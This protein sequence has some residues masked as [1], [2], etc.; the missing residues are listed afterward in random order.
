[1]NLIKIG[2]LVDG[3]V[4][5]QWIPKL[6]ENKFECFALNYFNTIGNADFS[7]LSKK[8]KDAVGDSG[9]TVSCISVYAN[10]LRDDDKITEWEKC[11]DNARLFGAD[12]V[13]GFTGR[14][15]GK[16]VE[17]NIP[18]FKE[19][20]TE[21]AK[22]AEDKGVKIAFENCYMGGNWHN[23]SWNI[24]N[25]PLAW[26][27]MFDSVPYDNIGIE[28]E[29]SHHLSFLRDPLKSLKKYAK[30]VFHIHGKDANI[31]WDSIKEYGID[32]ARWY[33]RDRMP[34]YGD[35]NWKEVCSILYKNE[36]TGTIDI[37]GW[38][39][40]YLKNEFEFTGQVAALKYL[41]ECR[42]GE[43]ITNP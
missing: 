31:D 3:S 8:V 16:S 20:F 11:I 5:L 38:H 4:I 10:P 17:D 9:L 21:L 2:T 43:F 15:D 24:A 39:D 29:P 18:R 42:G 40:P 41:K 25:S 28:W 19:V 13:T 33:S 35:T 14:L 1:M 37:E 7:E 6:I 32:G 34:G 36:Y 30:K 26:D 27:M 12:M 23:G 22:R